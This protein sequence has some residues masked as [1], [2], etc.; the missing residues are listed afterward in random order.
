[1]MDFIVNLYPLQIETLSTV[2]G[3]SVALGMTE[4]VGVKQT[5]RLPKQ[6]TDFVSINASGG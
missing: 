2:W 1:M 4:G 3:T 6:S 5:S